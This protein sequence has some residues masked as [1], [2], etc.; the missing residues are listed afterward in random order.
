MYNSFPT[1]RF[2]PFIAT[3]L[4]LSLVHAAIIPASTTVSHGFP[5]TNQSQIEETLHSLNRYEASTKGVATLK[6]FRP[7]PAAPFNFR[8]T[9]QPSWFLRVNS[10][11][12]PR[13]TFRQM[14]AMIDL[15]YK[16]QEIL[17]RVDPDTRMQET[18]YI[19][20]ATQREPRDLTQEDVEVI[21]FNSAEEPGAGYKAVD[22]YMALDI[23]LGRMLPQHLPEFSRT[24][25]HRAEMELRNGSV[26]K[27]RKVEIRRKTDDRA[28]AVATA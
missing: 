2:I 18:S 22:M 7:W 24:V 10:Y 15:C 16:A 28:N 19:F 1:M 17:K 12:G 3:V 13:L 20:R 14:H 11:D 9:T 8:S 21:F 4:H 5:Y 26:L 23:M 6:T 25:I 27:F